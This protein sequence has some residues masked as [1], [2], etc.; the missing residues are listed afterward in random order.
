MSLTD[1]E[2]CT[3]YFND[4]VHIEV[5]QLPQLTLDETD[6]CKGEPSFL[7]NSATPMGGGIL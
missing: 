7:L 3:Q 4:D 5:K 2:G 6:I 1:D